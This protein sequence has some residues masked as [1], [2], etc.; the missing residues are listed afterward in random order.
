MG[1]QGWNQKV[2]EFPYLIMEKLWN[3]KIQNEHEQLIVC[4]VESRN[5]IWAPNKSSWE[6]WGAQFKIIIEMQVFVIII[7]IIFESQITSS[8]FLYVYWKSHYRIN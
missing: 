7:I 3:L 5:S 1:T 2:M 8:V 6:S 4:L